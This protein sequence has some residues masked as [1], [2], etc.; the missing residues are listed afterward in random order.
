MDDFASLYNLK[1]LIKS[2][3]CFKSDAN[4]PCIDLILT[5]RSSCFQNSSTIE[6]GLSDFH[7]LV[8]T[9][10]KTNF[11]KKP[12]RVTIYRKYKNYV[13]QNYLNDLNLSLAGVDLRRMPHDDF[14]DLLMRVLDKHAPLKTKFIR[15]NDQPFMTTELRREHMKRTRLLNRKRRSGSV[16]DESAYK[17][18]R[19]LCAN[20]LRKVKKS[21][22]GNLKPS[23]VCD[24]KKFWGT[25][26]PLFSEK[27][28][29]SDSISL[30]ENKV[31]VSDD[32]QVAEIFNDY[33]SNAVKYLNIDYFEHFSFDC[34]YSGREDSIHKAIEKYSRHPSILKIKENYPQNTSFSFKP[35]DLESVL[36]EVGNLDESKCSP[37]ESVPARVLKDIVDV[38][39][40]KIVF[41]FNSAINTGI[42]PQNPKL[43][44]KDV[45]QY[46]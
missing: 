43:F 42:F 32:K 37:I 28:I 36:K 22:Y 21:H 17:R 24:N 11:R 30:I 8:L 3:T 35:T 15:G 5:N 33:F 38:V 41:D 34:V 1:S 20:L 45:K 2:P 18:Q 14:D 10:L 13:S 25:V 39:G 23:S 7:H 6:T 4:P 40:P 29:S 12:P 44:K 9:V 46:K 16:G 19:N 31:I 27:C 26:K